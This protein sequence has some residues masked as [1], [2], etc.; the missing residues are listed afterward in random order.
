MAVCM[1]VVCPFTSVEKH[2]LKI[3]ARKMGYT[4]EIYSL[5]TPTERVPFEQQD[6]W[7]NRSEGK[8]GDILG[9]AKAAPGGDRSSGE[10]GR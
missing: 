8:T 4:V 10:L 7:Q 6:I 3:G 5:V 2:I 1:C 9:T